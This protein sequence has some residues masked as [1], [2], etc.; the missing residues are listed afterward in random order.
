MVLDLL[1]IL[2]KRRTSKEIKSEI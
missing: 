1:I 2:V